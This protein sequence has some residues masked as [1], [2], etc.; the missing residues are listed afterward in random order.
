MCA[1]VSGTD[2][3]FTDN[4]W[5]PNLNLLTVASNG[6]GG[7]GVFPGNSIQ[8]GCL[9]RLQGALFG[10]NAVEFIAGAV[11]A[12]HQGPIVASTIVFAPGAELKPFTTL[13]TVSNGLPGQSLSTTT[14]APP[15]NFTG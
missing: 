11:G 10:T 7:L 3:D 2:C 4:A 15:K 1:V 14:V 12:K 8:L 6:N 9:D 13:T 5:N